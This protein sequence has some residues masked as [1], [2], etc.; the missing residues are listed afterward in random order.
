MDDFD[1]NVGGALA[2]AGKEKVMVQVLG[3]RKGLGDKACVVSLRYL[4]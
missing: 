4:D 3:T 1:K 2:K